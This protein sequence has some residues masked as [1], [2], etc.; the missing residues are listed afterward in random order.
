MPAAGRYNGAGPAAPGPAWGDPYRCPGRTPM[1]PIQRLWD[2]VEEHIESRT[3]DVCYRYHL[4]F[5]YYLHWFRRT[6]PSTRADDPAWREFCW[7][8]LEELVEQYSRALIFAR[9]TLAAIERM[10]DR[11][12][13]PDAAG[14]VRRLPLHGDL[15][16]VR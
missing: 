9:E 11:D 16:L 4:L 10:Q 15:V 13:Y 7:D 1:D 8:Q 5:V 14:P 2:C 3:P 6:F 12:G